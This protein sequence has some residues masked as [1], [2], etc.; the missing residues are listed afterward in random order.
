MKKEI[1]I[2]ALSL[3]STV[4]GGV[5]LNEEHSVLGGVLLVAGMLGIFYSVVNFRKEQ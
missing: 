3:M 1:I 2:P 4:I 5:L